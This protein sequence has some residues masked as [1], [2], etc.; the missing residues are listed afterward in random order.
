MSRR[1]L[2]RNLV[3]D[4]VQLYFTVFCS[5][6]LRSIY[7]QVLAG[8]LVVT[9]L[10]TTCASSVGRIR[11]TGCLFSICQELS[12]VWVFLQSSP[13]TVKI[14]IPVAPFLEWPSSECKINSF[15]AGSSFYMNLL[16]SKVSTPRVS[17]TLRLSTVLRFYCLKFLHVCFKLPV[18]CSVAI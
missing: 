8:L 17:S 4:R 10:E 16:A 18:L 13:S 3:Q 2:C 11:S 15:F 6:A 9:L 5:S 1:K 7:F 12:V 14:D